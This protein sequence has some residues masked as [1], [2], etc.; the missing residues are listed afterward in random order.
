MPTAEYGPNAE[1]PI[2]GVAT[3][4]RSHV[5]RNLRHRCRDT[6]IDVRLDTQHL[7]Q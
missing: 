5:Q 3:D 6:R 2:Y 7:R 4:A 1:L